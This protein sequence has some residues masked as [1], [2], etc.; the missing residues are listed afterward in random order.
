MALLAP[1]SA[2]REEV[3]T[4][5]AEMGVAMLVM[6][7]AIASGTGTRLQG[8]AMALAYIGFVAF[9]SST[10]TTTVSAPDSRSRTRSTGR[11]PG[12]C[13]GPRW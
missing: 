10:A 3:T 6:L 4:Y 8:V 1:L 5:G 13:S 12:R 7:F 9:R 11:C 2:T